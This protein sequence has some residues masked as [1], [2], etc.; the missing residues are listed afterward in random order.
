MTYNLK[1]ISGH[2]HFPVIEYGYKDKYLLFLKDD[3]LSLK[4]NDESRLSSLRTSYVHIHF[5][6]TKTFPNDHVVLQIIDNP[7]LALLNITNHKNYIS[8]IAELVLKG[9]KFIKVPV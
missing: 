6:D 7:S 3:I 4:Y 5:S 9:V 8:N 1:V 2:E